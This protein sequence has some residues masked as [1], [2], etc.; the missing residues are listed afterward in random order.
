MKIDSKTVAALDVGGKTD[1]IYFDDSL[2]GFGYR[3]RAGADGKVRRSWIVQYRRAGRTRRVLL[4][5]AAVL[6]AEQARAGEEGLGQGRARRGPAR[7]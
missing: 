1:I 7:G 5:S 3:L 2:P 4:G 6:T